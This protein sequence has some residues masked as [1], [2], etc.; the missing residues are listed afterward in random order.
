MRTVFFNYIIKLVRMKMIV[1]N[2]LLCYI[3]YDNISL[4]FAGG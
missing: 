3:T 1:L 2:L 4:R